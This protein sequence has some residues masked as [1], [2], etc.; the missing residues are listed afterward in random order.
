MASGIRFAGTAAPPA[1][2]ER[3]MSKR[4]PSRRSLRRMVPRSLP[5]APNRAAPG[6]S[7]GEDEQLPR[8][9]V[10]PA[11][12]RRLAGHHGQVPVGV[13]EQ[14]ELALLR[15][16]NASTQRSR[17]PSGTSDGGSPSRESRPDSEAGGQVDAA[18]RGDARHRASA[19]VAAS[20]RLPKW[21]THV[22]SARRQVRPSSRRPC[23]TTPPARRTNDAGSTASPRSSGDR[24]CAQRRRSGG[25]EVAPVEGRGRGR[26]PAGRGA[27]PPRWLIGASAGGLRRRH[28]E[29]VVGPDEAQGAAGPG[30][31][32]SRADAAA[33]VPTPGST[34]PRT[35]PAPRCG[36]ARTRVWLPART[37][38]G[39]M[40]WVRSM[41]VVPGAACI[42]AC[43][44]PTNSSCV[45]KS[46]R[47]K[48]VRTGRYGARSLS[49]AGC[50][51]VPWRRPPPP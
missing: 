40:W 19:T 10:E 35:T 44:T 20:W 12:R 24:P 43:T 15:S 4:P 14:A 29:P 41:T 17:T 45:P 7:P 25:E 33:D 28:Q 49:A 13:D 46:E 11:R 48:T 30:R 2:R 38:K 8:G 51:S 5:A 47:K 3:R 21:S 32:T 34:T 26:Q 31:A 36:T 16:P 18:R 27:A 23:S 9:D 39:G 37:S 42:T 1:R 50:A 22:T 6:P